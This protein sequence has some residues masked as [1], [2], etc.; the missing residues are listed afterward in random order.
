MKIVF[1]ITV[2]LSYLGVYESLEA[3]RLLIAVDSNAGFTAEEFAEKSGATL[4]RIDS[5]NPYRSLHDCFLET[6]YV[7]LAQET[8]EENVGRLSYRLSLR[9]GYRCKTF[10]EGSLEDAVFQAQQLLEAAPTSSS[11]ISTLSSEEQNRLYDL[12]HKINAV[13]TQGKIHYWAGRETLLGA[14]Y[15]QGLRP[16]DDYLH[17]FM[18]DLEEGKLKQLQDDF[19]AAGLV[20]HH[21]WKDF[22]K[23]FEKEGTPLIDTY[24][25]SGETLPFRYPAAN[26]F[27]M[28][29]E[30]RNEQEDVYVHRSEHFYSYWNFD[31][32]CYTQIQNITKVPFGPM[33]I[34]IPGDADAYLSRVFGLSGYP[35]LWKKYAQ[36]R[37]WEHRTESTARE[38][39]S[40][41]ELDSPLESR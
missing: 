26:L 19:D 11:E 10:S 35:D 37:C 20:L 3:S 18:L 2:F 23:I 9:Y 4:V 38:G 15:Y 24:L 40:F 34:P 6:P 25:H 5:R 30:K 12:M 16:W 17:L 22:Y 13:L 14:S 33:M 27:V 8:K 7:V 32:F 39:A 28:T 41:V 1:F 36:E 31:R 21:Y 29:L